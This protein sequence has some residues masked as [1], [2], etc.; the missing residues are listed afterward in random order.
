MVIY[1]KLTIGGSTVSDTFNTEVKKIVGDAN[2]SSTFT[3]TIDNFAGKNASTYTIG[4]EVQI[5]ADKDVNPPTTNIFTGILEN[6]RFPSR[7]LKEETILQGRDYSARLMDRTV[8][9]EVY[10]NLPAGSIVKD[11]INKYTDDITVNN[12]EDSN[13]TI[14]RIAFNHTP[15]FD[16]VKKLSD[17][18]NFT[19][20]VDNDKDLNFKNKSAT[21]SGKTFDNT[22]V[23]RANFR[24]RRD[25][26]FNEVWV[27][28]DRYLDSFKE[29]FT[30]DGTGSVFTLTHKPHNSIIDIGSPITEA[31][32]QV[33]GVFG[34]SAVP[35]SG[36]DYLVDFFD[37]QIIFTS[38]TTLGYSSIPENNAM[39]TVDYQRS[40]PIV[41]VGRNQESINK[42]G[43]R[44]KK[45]TDKEIKDPETAVKRL[46]RELDDTPIP[47]KQGTLNI[48]GVVDV[49]PSQ[50]AFVN[51]PNQ[52]VVSQTYDIISA[53]Y[54]FNKK[55]NLKEEVL[56][57]DVNKKIDDLADTIKSLINDV[58]TIQ[59]QDVDT[60]DII[61][62][63]EIA[64][65][66]IGIRPSGITVSTRGLGSSFILGKGY[67]GVAGPTFG[68]ILG[69]VVA[70]GINVLGDS[71][72]G[73]HVFWSGGYF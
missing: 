12:V 46:T 28:G 10:T 13:T 67:H 55:N 17:L 54:N 32:R 11:I 66:S 63:F 21:S 22:N 8:E 57:V 70:S 52:N 56:I 36:T 72:S 16:A 48:K 39:I 7:A 33:G 50:T 58:K 45:I 6:Q 15:V 9:P 29:E 30:G 20:Y 37:K 25:T 49:I 1:S 62:R 5:F 27:Y 47:I 44:V 4:D 64:A 59:S 18:A 69:S 43:K 35:A 53:N 40:L 14:E 19:F 41:K 61:T 68:G 26:V 65:G 42:Y 23:M 34:M 51:L 3:T 71:R 31:T 2:S 24:E 60:A 73:L 38:G